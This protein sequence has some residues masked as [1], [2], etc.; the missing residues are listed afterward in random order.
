MDKIGS[1]ERR[2]HSSRLIPYSYYNCMIP[3]Y[4]PN[5]PLHYHSEFEINYIYK[6]KGEFRCGDERYITSDGDILIILPNT[7]H[8]IDPHEDYKQLYD[9]IVFSAEMLGSSSNDRCSAECIRPLLN[10]KQGITCCI[11][12][13]DTGYEDLRPLV[14]SIFT[15]AKNRSAGMDL[16]LKSELMRLFWTLRQI[17]AIY[18]KAVISDSLTERIRPT[19]TYISENFREDLTVSQL[20]EA[21]HFSKS[22]F[23]SCFK[24]AVG[25]GVMEY[26]AG[27]RLKA[28]CE[29]LSETDHSISDIALECG[30]KNL[31]N[32]NRQF[33]KSVGCTPREYRKFGSQ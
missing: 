30:F 11:S 12:K 31:S 22:H 23:M 8:S 10:G 3:V 24:Q 6:G 19:L 18:K 4:F 15:C 9:T 26:I 7:L 33:K 25:V 13:G 2:Q 28:A 32:F 5:V 27:L 21:A 16:L 17:G 20:A 29:A 14:E 1:K